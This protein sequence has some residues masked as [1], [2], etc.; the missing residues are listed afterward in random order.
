M[1]FVGNLAGGEDF[2]EDSGA[3]IET[4]IVV[5]ATV[6]INFHVRKRSG[7]GESERAVALPENGIGRQAEDGAEHSGASGRRHTAVSREEGGKFFDQRGAVGA[8]GRK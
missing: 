5:R 4:E 8:D 1:E 6:E 2:V 3:G 7:T